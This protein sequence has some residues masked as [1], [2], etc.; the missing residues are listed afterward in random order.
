MIQETNKKTKIEAFIDF[1][2]TAKSLIYIEP[3]NAPEKIKIFTQQWLKNVDYKEKATK[4]PLVTGTPVAVSPTA[5]AWVLETFETPSYVREYGYWISLE[6]V[7]NQA[8][9]EAIGLMKTM[10][11][12]ERE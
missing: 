11:S 2:S 5:K 7:K 10:L 12:L 9:P 8:I 6:D 3:E 1:H 4:L